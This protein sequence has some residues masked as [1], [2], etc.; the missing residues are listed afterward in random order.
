M[1]DA[2]NLSVEVSNQIYD[3]GKIANQKD[4]HQETPSRSG[5]V[6][7]GR[8]ISRSYVNVREENLH[9]FSSECQFTDVWRSRLI[10]SC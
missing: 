6:K 9:N 5:L 7:M 2:Q 1:L 3:S 4:V 8:H 10:N